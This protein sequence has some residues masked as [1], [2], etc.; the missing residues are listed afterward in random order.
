MLHYWGKQRAYW[1]KCPSSYIVKKCPVGKLLLRFVL[2]VRATKAYC[3]R[4]C[5]HWDGQFKIQVKL[6]SFSLHI[7]GLQL[8]RVSNHYIIRNY[9][10]MKIVRQYS[11]TVMKCRWTPNNRPFRPFC[12]KSHTTRS[13]AVNAIIHVVMG[14][15]CCWV[16]L[17]ECICITV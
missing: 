2:F 14:L 8:R 5:L 15:Q 1:G 3:Y 9:G 4:H 7:V 11:V 12:S 10:Y 6:K 16:S 13:D 17:S